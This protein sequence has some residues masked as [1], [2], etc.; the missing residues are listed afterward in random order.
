M[1]PISVDDGRRVSNTIHATI[2]GQRIRAVPD[3]DEVRCSDLR[4]GAALR[5]GAELSTRRMRRC[6]RCGGST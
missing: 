3:A 5:D 6:G 4:D 2:G 1:T